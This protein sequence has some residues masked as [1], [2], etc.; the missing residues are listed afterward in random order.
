MFLPFF[1]AQGR[2]RT[3]TILRSRDFKSL[4]S[5]N[6]ATRAILNNIFKDLEATPGF[7]PGDDGFADHCLT[8]WLRRHY[9]IKKN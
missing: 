9:F 5:T 6:F 1:G 4:A 2:T 7:E 3:G 8:T